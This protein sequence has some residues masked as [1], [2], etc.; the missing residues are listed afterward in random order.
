[1]RRIRE[2]CLR[3]GGLFNKQRKD[4]ELEVEIEGHLQMHIEDNLRLGMRP[5]EAR[6]QALVKLGGVESTKEAYRDQ[7]GLPMLETLWADIRFGARMLRKNPG[8][9]T[10]VVLTLALGVGANTAIF[11]VVRAMLIEPLPYHQ[12]D[13]LV[14]V[15]LDRSDIKYSRAPL[16][17]PDL[18]DL[19]EGS[20]TCDEFAGIWASGTVALAGGNSD[21][22]QLRTSV[23]TPNFFNVLG[24]ECALGRTFRQEDSEQGAPPTILLAWDLFERR[25]GADPALIGRQI[26][27]DD[28]WTTVIG[29]MPKQFSLMLPPD[30][31]VPDHLQVW[32]PMSR[33]F[34]QWPRGSLYLRVIGR[35]KTGANLAEAQQD[36]ASIAKR[37][38]A[39]TGTPRAFSVVSLK[40]DGVREIR[41]PLLALF[42]GAT[43]LL[44]IACV[45]VAGLLTSRAMLRGRETAVCLAL[46]V[47]RGR[48]AQQSLVEG[49][50]LTVL[51]LVAGW[52]VG[53]A[54]LKLL[55]M[56]LPD[57]LSRISASRIDLPVV[58]FMSGIAIIW[59]LLFSLTPLLEWRPLPARMS[60]ERP[61]A[62]LGPYSGPGRIQ[63]RSALV[64][65]QVALSLVLLVGAGLFLRTFLNLQRVE[66]GYRADRHITFRI[67]LPDA[68]YPSTEARIT[69]MDLLQHRLRAIAG[70]N[71]A[72]AISHLP[73]DDLPN[74]GLTYALDSAPQKAGAPF[75]NSRAITPGLLE[76]L[77]AQ[78]IE[79]RF[80]SDGDANREAP[81]VI[82]DDILAQRLWPNQSA[83]GR[84][85]LLG[86]QQPDRRVSVVGVVGHLKQ[87][88]LVADLSPQIF[89]PF[90]IWQRSPMAFVLRT[91]SFADPNILAANV[92]SAVAEFDPHLPI[93]DL[94]PMQSYVDGARSIRR[95]TMWLAGAFAV[96]ALVLSCVGIYGVLA[97]SVTLRRRE[98]G[99]RGALGAVPRQL[100][101]L[102]VRQSLRLAL[103]GCALGLALA[104]GLMRLLQ[105]QLFGTHP[106]DPVTCAAALALV[107]A[108][109]LTASWIPASRIARISPMEALRVE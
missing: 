19:R 72:G 105:N 26:L 57:S 36:I 10:V 94:R 14:F 9:T 52:C 8:F 86:Q 12:P 48:L 1:M 47:T 107:I 15:W 50:M 59:G 32:Q 11:S 84:Q 7:R 92:R 79:G 13:R 60:I 35:M 89:L 33:E 82:I 88:S 37:I 31:A 41:G 65:A 101:G 53:S 102:V 6:R 56:C 80:F 87:R 63:M 55:L 45:N 49:G 67:A 43:I 104:L 91:D 30:A 66:L 22:E 58:A 96:S 77:N 81:V 108:A 25:F 73:F 62:S 4:R 40:A 85:F 103:T 93:Y 18:R 42:A 75:A 34:D 24:V 78:L 38:S 106:W 61:F 28:H 27:A 64:V 46:G 109:A 100:L 5:E 71:S 83:V 29:V 44:A 69:G 51:G 23:V 90:R 99:V 3:F 39:E 17:S 68:R 97:C 74:W 20:Q 2:F 16:S 70:V 98:F 95:F 76:T 21:P 54:G